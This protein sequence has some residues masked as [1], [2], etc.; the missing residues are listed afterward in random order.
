MNR[1]RIG[2]LG[3]LAGAYLLFAIDTAPSKRTPIAHRLLGPLAE[4]ASDVQW[5]RFQR[6][7]IHGNTERTLFF[8]ESALTL[9][10]ESTAA[11]E[12]FAQHLALYLSSPHR[13]A[14]PGR[15][16]AW[17]R[18]GIEVTRRGKE[19]AAEPA[20]LDFLR[21]FL[22]YSKAHLDAA[23]YPGGKRALLEEALPALRIARQ[24]GISGAEYLEEAA[25]KELSP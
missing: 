21:G 17:F 12:L 18:A 9:D 14:D 13:E 6:A 24:A 3:C 22:L 11:W 5:I 23:V 8:A 7:R 2:A 19:R 15:R 1:R 4:L 10:P 20:R 25:E 16:L